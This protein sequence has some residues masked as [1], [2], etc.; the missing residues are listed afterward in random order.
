[1]E[2]EVIRTELEHKLDKLDELIEEINAR[3]ERLKKE[4]EQ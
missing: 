3:E 2:I 4:Q 1:M